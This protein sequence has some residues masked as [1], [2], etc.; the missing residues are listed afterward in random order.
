MADD[1]TPRRTAP[2][3][4]HGAS[5]LIVGLGRF[6]AALAAELMAL[7]YEVLGVDTD[8]GI[9]RRHAD[10]LTRAIEADASDP[11]VLH[12]LGAS[13]YAAA[14]VA[15]GDDIEASI[16][17]ASGLVEEGAPWVMAKA[18][19]AE[20]GRILKLVG[21]DEVV[22]PEHDMGRRAAHLLGGRIINWFQLD[23]DFAMVETVVPAALVGMTLS[24]TALRA[25]RNLTVVAV[26]PVGSTFTY[27]TP[28][29]RLGEGDVL[30]V[31]GPGHA[32]EEFARS[33]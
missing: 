27:A 19:S 11:E 8:E 22:F 25:K 10:D 30:V 4:P 13:D 20:H 21:A 9:V 32:A 23:E 18:V 1:L 24:E 5:I 6:G 28:D 31:A 2:D 29:T 12:Q 7:D 16:L 26:K 3:L 33:S 17:T 15:I 14:V